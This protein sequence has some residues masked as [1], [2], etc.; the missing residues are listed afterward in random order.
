MHTRRM[1]RSVSIY[2]HNIEILYVCPGQANRYKNLWLSCAK[3]ETEREWCTVLRLRLHCY[4]PLPHKIKYARG[5]CG[6]WPPLDKTRCSAAHCFAL[7]FHVDFSILLYYFFIL[8]FLFTFSPLTEIK[9]GGKKI[10]SSLYIYRYRYRKECMKNMG[11]YIFIF[12]QLEANRFF[13]S[14]THIK[15]KMHKN[16]NKIN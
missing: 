15:K 8:F 9:W 1:A 11:I 2:I 13:L 5:P 16:E 10:I 14:L 3:C 4:R 12:S 6:L 7:A